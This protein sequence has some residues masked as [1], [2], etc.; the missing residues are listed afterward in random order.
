MKT[1]ILILLLVATSAFAGSSFDAG[2]AA[3]WAAGWT[4]YH[5]RYSMVPMTPF[6][7]FP[8]FGEDDFQ[9]GFKYGYAAATCR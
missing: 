4:D 6:P 7:P 5:G 1:L 3:G 2:W 9:G 8:P